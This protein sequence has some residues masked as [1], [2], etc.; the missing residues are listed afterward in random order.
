M[1]KEFSRTERI[2]DLMQR[3]L[4]LYIQR[5]L[6]DPRLGMVTVS[7]VEVTKDLAYAKVYITQ[8]DDS[9]EKIQQTLAILNKASGFMR[10]LLGKN[11]KLRTIPQLTFYYDTTYQVA[12]R[13][14]SLIDSIKQ[15]PQGDDD[16]ES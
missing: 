9:E 3:E 13:I 5:E 4:A 6:K 11:I 16:V 10:K 14:D 8:F 15:P 1:A 12:S 2:S 7:G